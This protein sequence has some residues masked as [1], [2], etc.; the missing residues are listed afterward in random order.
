MFRKL[1]ED[2]RRQ[3]AQQLSDAE[4]LESGRWR[5]G[6]RDGEQSSSIASGKRSLAARLLGL[7]KAYEDLDD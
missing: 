5:I 6:N 3:A 4:E 2:Y 1:I 7:G